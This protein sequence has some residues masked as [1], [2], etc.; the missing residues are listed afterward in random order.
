MKRTKQWWATLTLG[1]RSELHWLE[2]YGSRWS[3]RGPAGLPDGCVECGNCSTPHAGVG[4]CPACS[5]RLD[6][7][8]N[9]AN[10][11]MRLAVRKIEKKE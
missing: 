9:K 7:L 5:T 2:Y 11:A 10:N 4:L 6:E 1:E 8:I 3:T